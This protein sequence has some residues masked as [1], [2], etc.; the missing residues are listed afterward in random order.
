MGTRSSSSGAGLVAGIVSSSGRRI[1]WALLERAALGLRQE[2]SEQRPG[3]ERGRQQEERRSEPES[4]GQKAHHR[5]RG[6]AQTAADV[7]AEPHRGGADLRREQLR[8]DRAEAG[9]EAG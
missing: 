3:Q 1:L 2:E 9:E 8:R 5:G 4:R 7:V 6:G